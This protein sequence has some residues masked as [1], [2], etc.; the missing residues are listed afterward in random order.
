MKPV[1]STPRFWL[2]CVAAACGLAATAPAWSQSDIGPPPPAVHHRHGVAYV[3]GGIGSD[4]ARQMERMASQWPLALEFAV[5]DRADPKG[6]AFAA[7]VAVSIQDAHGH[8]V[9]D[10][11]HTDGPFLL[12]RVQPGRY[13]VSADYAGR[14]IT[15]E[16]TVPA[17][18]PGRAVFEWPDSA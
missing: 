15:R 6:A 4:E 8:T 7:D 16:V 2:A 12:A 11:V 17:H 3:S 5:K 9:L 13:R 14:T 1:S 18:G 10:G